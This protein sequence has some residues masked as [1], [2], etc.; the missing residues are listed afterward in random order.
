M[1]VFLFALGPAVA[2]S[3]GGIVA[4]F[5]PPSAAARSGVQHFAAGVLLCALATELLPD[6]VHRRLPMATIGGFALGVAAMLVMK[7]LAETAATKWW[8]LARR[9]TACF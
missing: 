4:A 9:R 3:V 8:R 1:D 6:V 5:R 7:R 2:V